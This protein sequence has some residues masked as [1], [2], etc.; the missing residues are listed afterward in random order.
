MGT[1]GQ[2]ERAWGLQHEKHCGQGLAR[3]PGGASEKE[4]VGLCQKSKELVYACCGG[5]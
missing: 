2:G 5:A 4:L 1:R 3:R